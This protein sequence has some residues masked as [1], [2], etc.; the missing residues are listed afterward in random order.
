[1]RSKRG[2]DAGTANGAASRSV[3]VSVAPS[4]RGRTMDRL[5]SGSFVRWAGSDRERGHVD[6]APLLPARERRLD[7]LH[8]LGA[9][10]ERPSVRRVLGDVADERLPLQLEAVLV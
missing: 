1:M 4:S 7:E 3:H 8:A 5:M 9:F 6:P 2:G 10:L